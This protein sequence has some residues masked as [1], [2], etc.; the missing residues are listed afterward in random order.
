MERMHLDLVLPVVE[1]IVAEIFIGHMKKLTARF[2]NKVNATNQTF[3]RDQDNPSCKD[4]DIDD[5]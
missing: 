1:R 2:I 4:R 5:N 3:K